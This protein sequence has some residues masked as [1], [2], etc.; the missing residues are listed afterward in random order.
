MEHGNSVDWNSY[1]KFIDSYWF[2]IIISSFSFDGYQLNKYVSYL[3]LQIYLYGCLVT[4]MLCLLLL[5][6]RSPPLYHAYMIM[7]SFLWVQIIS[8]YQFIK[9]LW[10]HISGRRMN[11][12]IKLLAITAV[13]VFILEFL[14]WM[15][16]IIFSNLV[17]FNSSDEEIFGLRYRLT[18]SLR[19]SSILCF[20]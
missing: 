7:T 9:A 20:F 3:L 17:R 1:L 6:E 11:Y 15:V 13:S 12:I 19:G 16:I 18:A 4:G 2:H 8:E 5:L 14:V 10:K